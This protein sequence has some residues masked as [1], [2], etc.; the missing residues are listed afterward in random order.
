MAGIAALAM[1]AAAGPTWAGA[2]TVSAAGKGR[3]V[4]IARTAADMGALKAEASR[5]R[6][7][8]H[9]LGGTR[10]MAVDATPA[11]VSAL[12]SS[13]LAS[14]VAKDH[15]VRLIDPEAAQSVQERA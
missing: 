4:V 5:Q 15:V 6:A 2:A 12:R 8:V 3:Y 13:G 14:T 1:A 9:D 7:V 11:A 10:T